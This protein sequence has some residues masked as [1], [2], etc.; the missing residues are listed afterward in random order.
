VVWR[1]A[2]A[3]AEGAVA[4]AR[5]VREAVVASD[6]LAIARALVVAVAV[7]AV[8]VAAAEGAVAVARAVRE[9]VVASDGLA[10]ARALVVAVAVVA[11]AAAVAVESYLESREAV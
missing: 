2:V 10:I 1:A 6:G 3:A 11:V 8:A 9:A 5:A 4:V 7:V